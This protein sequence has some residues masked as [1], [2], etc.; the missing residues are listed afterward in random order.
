MGNKKSKDRIPA[1]M[2]ECPVC[3]VDI[4]VE[5]EHIDDP[6]GAA[7]FIKHWAIGK[8]PEKDWPCRCSYLVVSQL[9]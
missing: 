6:P 8:N 7:S 5:V 2:M 1:G 3:G 9:E 4:A